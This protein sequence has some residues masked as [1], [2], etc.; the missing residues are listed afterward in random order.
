MFPKNITDLLLC[1]K[2]SKKN[3]VAENNLRN[4]LSHA[5]F[6]GQEFGWFWPWVSWE[7]AVMVSAKAP[8]I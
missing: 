6:V 5:M 1:C 7:A 8:G 2:L 4:L 3:L